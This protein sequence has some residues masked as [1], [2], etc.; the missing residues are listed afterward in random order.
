MVLVDCSLIVAGDV[1]ILRLMSTGGESS[2]VES[3]FC[4]CDRWSSVPT[5]ADDEDEY[6]DGLMDVAVCALSTLLSLP[7]SKTAVPISQSP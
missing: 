6:S 1:A 2:Q 5:G 7:D 4:F 3:C